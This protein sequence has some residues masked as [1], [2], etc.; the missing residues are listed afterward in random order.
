M[1]VDKEG[2]DHMLFKLLE[3]DQDAVV[4]KGIESELLPE[5]VGFSITGFLSNDV[6]L[7]QRMKAVF[8]AGILK[9]WSILEDETQ[10]RGSFKTNQNTKSSLSQS[11]FDHDFK[12]CGSIYN[13]CCFD[14]W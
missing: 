8:Q 13:L 6:N 5:T 4:Y 3:Q 9:F 11:K 7:Q 1:D 14:S 12:Y 10:L 2:L